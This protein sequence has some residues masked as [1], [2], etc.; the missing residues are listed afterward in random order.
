MSLKKTNRIIAPFLLI[1][2]LTVVCCSNKQQ[3]QQ[4]D[5]QAQEK[6]QKELKIRQKQEARKVAKLRADSLAQACFPDTAT[7]TK[8]YIYLTIDDGPSNATPLINSVILTEKVPVSIFAVG[9]KGDKKSLLLNNLKLYKDNPYIELYNHSY[10][11]A[12]DH[13]KL[14]YTNPK[15]VL[16]DF[17]KSDSILDLN[18]KVVRMP[19]RN[20]WRVGKRKRNDILSG[21]SAADTLAAHGY[22]LIGWDLEWSHR[23]DGVPVQSAAQIADEV[24]HLFESRHT[25]TKNNVVILLHDQMFTQPWEKDE[26]QKFLNILK[27]DSS[28]IFESAK[29]YPSR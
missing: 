24:K 19:G 29:K 4:L 2:G 8:K 1:L 26:L 3:M 12:N 17:I 6:E 28:Y 15:H 27:A 25:F 7:Y 21:I 10:S 9:W 14:Y 22:T 13:Y 23:S 18:T 11:H 16:A 20:M 5:R